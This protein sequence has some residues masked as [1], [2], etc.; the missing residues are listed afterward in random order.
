M[1]EAL[2]A[3]YDLGALALCFLAI[4]LLLA[5]KGIVKAVAGLFDFSIFGFRPLHSLATGLENG[6][7]GAL[8]DAIKGV[9]RATAHFES[10]LIDAFGLLIAIP[11]LL[12][13][14]V[15]A[16]LEYLWSSALRPTIHSI[17]DA[18]KATADAALARA[19]AL[20][21]T[22]A[23][24]L[25]SA[26]AYARGQAA[27]ALGAAEGYVEHRLEAF[28][29]TIRGDIAAGVSAAEGYADQAVSKL[30]AA[31]DAAVAGAVGLAAVAKSEAERLAAA[32]IATAEAEAG[33]ALS[34]ED[35][36]L[37]QA[38]SL[39]Q[40][41][42]TA[43]LDGLGGVVINVGDD[44]RTIEAGLGAAG[45]GA[46][47]ASIPALATLVHAIATEAGL[48]NAACRG[49]VKGICGTDPSRWADLLLGLAAL[50]FS[51]TLADVVEAA[52]GAIG[53]A[54]GLLA[55]VG[56]LPGDVV[57]SAGSAI[58]RAALAIGG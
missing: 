15:K 56:N 52:A 47:I 19:I 36:A 17:T 37:R 24:I 55:E 6:V 14:G 28:A 3:G 33:A 32:A 30:R 21:K 4:G 48:E 16:A 8:D 13:L 42:G 25:A 20:E 11:I 54:G 40:A 18:I 46:L 9:E 44:L 29:Q 43:A 22:V 31:E 49:K 45:L 1:A 27:A 12:G 34:A 50:G 35:Q 26:E 39:A 41:A 58:G 7:V 51:F 23:G 2:E 57:N 10:G 5:T 53:Q 38:I